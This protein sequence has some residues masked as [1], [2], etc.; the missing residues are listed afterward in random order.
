MR[1]QYEIKNVRSLVQKQE[2][3]VSLSV[4]KPVPIFHSFLS[5]S[6]QYFFKRLLFKSSF[7]FIA[8]LRGK[9]R[10][11]LYILCP[12]PRHRLPY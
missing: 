6:S 8:S 1:A 7:R 5:Q 4:L 9:Y 11:F 10:D 2:K 3:K 12:P